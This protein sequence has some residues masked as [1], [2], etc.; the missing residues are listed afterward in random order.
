[1]KDLYLE[2]S[3]LIVDDEPP[4]VL[5]LERILSRL[6][7]R[8][9]LSTT[10]S[11]QVVSIFT[12]EQPDLILLDLHMPHQ[13]GYEV[14]AALAP[15]QNE[16][17]CVPIVV[18]TADATIEAR[19][20]ALE[21]GASDFV[22]EPFDSVK[23]ALRIRNVLQTRFLQQKLGSQNR[24]LEERV[25]LRTVALERTLAELRA[26][27][28]QVIQQER[29]RALS[30]MAA[31]IAHDFNDLLSLILGY[32]ELLLPEN[33]V[34]V[35]AVKRT[36]YLHTL[37]ETARDAVDLVNR[38]G[39]FQRPR[40]PKNFHPAIS[41]PDLVRETV[42]LTTA[43]W[44]Q[45]TEADGIDIQLMTELG[46]DC[47]VVGDAGEVRDLI[48]NL[49]FNAVDAMPE[50]GKIT[51][52]C[53]A[54]SDRVILV[55]EDTGIGMTEEV[56]ERCLE[57]FFSTKVDH[58]SGLGL[59][60][61][62]GIVQ[63]HSGTLEVKSRP[64]LGSRFRVTIP[65]SRSASSLSSI[66]SPIGGEPQDILIV[67]D[68]PVLREVLAGNLKADRH[69]IVCAQDGADAIGK[70]QDRH[71][72]LVITDQAMPGMNGDQLAVALRELHPGLSVI[73]LT[74]FADAGLSQSDS[75]AVDFILGKPVDL[76]LLRQA[77]G[78]LSLVGPKTGDAHDSDGVLPNESELPPRYEAGVAHRH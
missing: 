3:I 27:Q 31:G 37:I 54:E 22:T 59:A 9:I 47:S 52:R 61:V 38:L 53:R 15:L 14:M 39:K 30:A 23:V 62:Y 77:I 55:I 45:Q 63:R 19:R 35:A 71:F 16:L 51:I 50:G 17:A 4:N 36:K 66:L 57:P 11:R 78:H 20:R 58:G 44:K 2:A 28:Q 73:L 21:L 24:I 40:L 12:E 69:R 26:T 10:D 1:M 42:D 5:L 72:D 76:A 65:R 70:I 48:T 43:K 33:D 8:N 68:Q 25:R 18:L 74:G 32:G 7:Y 56:Q 29:L 64:G 75:P 49:I 6:G 13:T 41:L 34:E 60:M 67:D 46:D